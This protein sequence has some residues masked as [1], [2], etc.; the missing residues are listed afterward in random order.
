MIDPNPKNMENNFFEINPFFL[1]TILSAH[2]KQFWQTLRIV[3]AK[4]PK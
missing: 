3:F 2:R 1:K 4:S